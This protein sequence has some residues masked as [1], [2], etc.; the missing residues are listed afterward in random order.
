MSLPDYNIVFDTIGEL[1][2]VDVI[3]SV[4]AW[5]MKLVCTDV[6]CVMRQ[7][8]LLGEMTGQI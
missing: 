4:V 7:D 3:C 5:D 6:T 1:S 8:L 2:Y